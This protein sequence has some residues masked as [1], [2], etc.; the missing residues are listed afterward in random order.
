MGDADRNN[1]IDADG[2]QLSAFDRHVAFDPAGDFESFLKQI[3]AKWAV[4][5]MADADRRPVQLLSVKNLRYS[6]K[7]RL[8]G[9]G[10]TEGDEP[11]TLSKRVDY[12]ELIR[13]V[14]LRRVDSAFE[15]DVVYLDVARQTFPQTYRGMTGFR[16]AWFVHVNPQTTYPRYIKTIDP[17][18]H[19]AN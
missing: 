17:S 15:A 1:L 5:L 4:Y 11:A 9:P 13:H 2:A 10:A 6:L 8:G 18:R 7:R 14:Y 19:T 3:P 16:P 12:R